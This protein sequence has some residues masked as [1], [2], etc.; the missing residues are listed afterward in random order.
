MK[1]R[2]L[3]LV[4]IMI[5]FSNFTLA[6]YTDVII[7][8]NIDA[9]AD[10]NNTT[11]A[12]TETYINQTDLFR[13]SKNEF[14]MFSSS[15]SVGTSVIASKYVSVYNIPIGYSFKSK[16]F[17]RNKTDAYE[18]LSF[19]V[20]LPVTQKKY[21]AFDLA[22]QMAEYKTTGLGDVVVKANY[23]MAMN[24]MI[25]SFGM[26]AK[27]ATAKKTNIIKGHDVPIGTGSTDLNFSLFFSKSINKEINVHSAVTYDFRGE[28]KK[29]V[30]TY[31]FGNKA[32]IIV[33]GDYFYK[34]CNIGSDFSY[35][36][37]GNDKQVEFSLESPG[38]TAIDAIPYVKV[39][40]TESMDAK[41]FGVIPISS[42]WKSIDGF[43]G[44]MPDPD[45]K[46]RF[47]FSFVYKL[48]K[49]AEQK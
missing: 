1:A 27:L 7:P 11:S 3:V 12:I 15:F 25:F 4:G 36:S 14:N 5:L 29:D 49:T 33:G 20:V 46:I 48:E 35:T 10:I 21:E 23:N 37:S 43:I 28:T 47:G 19:K 44:T 38:I 32:N 9:S 31:D 2:L 6:Q 13:N 41:F 22:G 16:L 40:I 17:F 34:I 45:R 8:Y 24:S 42:K 30:I 26:Q 18:N 39:S